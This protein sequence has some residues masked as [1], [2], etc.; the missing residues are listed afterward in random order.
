[1]LQQQKR[2]AGKSLPA[3][4]KITADLDKKLIFIK[5]ADSTPDHSDCNEITKRWKCKHL[6]CYPSAHNKTTRFDQRDLKKQS[7]RVN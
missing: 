4:P 7:A 6:R 3:C 1:M 5:L 2:Q